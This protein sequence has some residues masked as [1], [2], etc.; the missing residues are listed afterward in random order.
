MD[1]IRVLIVDDD[2]D[3]RQELAAQLVGEAGIRVTGQAGDGEEALA[4][5]EELSPDLRQYP[6]QAPRGQSDRNSAL[7]PAR[8]S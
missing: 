7:R 1:T 5:A 3:E 2:A 8:G 4:Q 6:G